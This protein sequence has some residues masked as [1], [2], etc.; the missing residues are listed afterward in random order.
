MNK[1]D[2]MCKVCGDSGSVMKD[3]TCPYCE[4]AGAISDNQ[5]CG[6]CDS[7]GTLMEGMDCSYCKAVDTA[8]LAGGGLLQPQQGLPP[9]RKKMKKDAPMKMEGGEQY[10]A[11]AFA[12]VPDPNTP[13]TW[14]LRLWDSPTTKETVAQV[15]RAATALTSAGF[16]GNKVQIPAADLAVLT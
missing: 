15:S 3:M 16:R 10:P 8:A 13:S 14:K 5:D 6:H 12:Y 7:T 1:S 4:G 2:Y 11:A 9:Q